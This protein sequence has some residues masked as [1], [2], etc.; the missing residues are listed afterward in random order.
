VFGAD[1][2]PSRSVLSAGFRTAVA[3]TPA[4][5]IGRWGAGVD[6]RCAILTRKGKSSANWARSWV[7]DCLRVAVAFWRLLHRRYSVFSVLPVPPL[8]QQ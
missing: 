8:K 6:A 1:P 5:P 4:T 3:Q 7:D 2:Y